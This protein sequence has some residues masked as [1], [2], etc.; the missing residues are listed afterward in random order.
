MTSTVKTKLVRSS[1][2]EFLVKAP[3]SR[4]PLLKKHIDKAWGQGLFNY[5]YQVGRMLSLAQPQGWHS[6]RGLWELLPPC[7]VEM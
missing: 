2:H 5:Y 4:L 3:S 6:E 1:L 7:V